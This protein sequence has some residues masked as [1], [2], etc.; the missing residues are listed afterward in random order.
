[1]VAYE[2]WSRTL[3]FLVLAWIAALLK[4]TRQASHTR[5]GGVGVIDGGEKNVL[6][7]GIVEIDS[8]RHAMKRHSSPATSG[9]YAEKQI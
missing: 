1:M 3:V 4:G 6:T 5:H 2:L 7:V 8:V 9:S